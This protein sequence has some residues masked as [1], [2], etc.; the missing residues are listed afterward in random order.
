[1]QNQIQ[2]D[3]VI[4]VPKAIVVTNKD[5]AVTEDGQE[6]RIEQLQDVLDVYP[7][8]LDL[9]LSRIDQ[10]DAYDLV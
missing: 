6:Y 5:I 10:E 8:C 9:T 3:K 7:V 4:R 1:M 2:V